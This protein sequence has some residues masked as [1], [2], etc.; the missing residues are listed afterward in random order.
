MAMGL[1]VPL[2]PALDEALGDQGCTGGYPLV[3]W[4]ELGGLLDPALEKCTWC[5]TGRAPV[6]LEL[7]LPLG[8]G[9]GMEWV[10]KSE[11]DY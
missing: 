3:Y 9:L 8:E 5:G 2:G 4:N 7:G 10:Q 6:G 1:L 11:W